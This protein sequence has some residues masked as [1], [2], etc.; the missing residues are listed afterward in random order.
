MDNNKAWPIKTTYNLVASHRGGRGKAVVKGC[1]IIIAR[2][3]PT[4]N[5][6]TLQEWHK[7]SQTERDIWVKQVNK[8]YNK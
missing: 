4:Q 6:K 1:R 5:H 2:G 3:T 7:C 8:E